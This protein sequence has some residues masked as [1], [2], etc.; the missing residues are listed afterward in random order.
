MFTVFQKLKVGNNFFSSKMNSDSMIS[1]ETKSYSD[2]NEVNQDLHNMT[3]S[4]VDASDKTS[5]GSCTS[6]CRICQL[7]KKEIG[8]FLFSLIQY[9]SLI[10]IPGRVGVCPIFKEK[11]AYA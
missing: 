7:G 6:V 10:V 11:N 8:G 5:S 9:S 4:L 3:G 1:H 2:E